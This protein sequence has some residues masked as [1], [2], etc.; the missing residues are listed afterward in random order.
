MV[1]D[2]RAAGKVVDYCFVPHVEYIFGL[3]SIDIAPVDN[4]PNS[5][6]GNMRK[7]ARYAGFNSYIQSA[8]Q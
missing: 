5:M 8:E 6:C 7:Y 2:T 4:Y 1:F 3:T